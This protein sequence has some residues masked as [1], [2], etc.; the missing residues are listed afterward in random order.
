MFPVVFVYVQAPQQAS[1]P[2]KDSLC[3]QEHLAIKLFLILILILI[4]RDLP[5]L[6]WGENN[7]NAAAVFVLLTKELGNRTSN[8]KHWADKE[9]KETQG[10]RKQ[11]KTS[12]ETWNR[13]V[14]LIKPFSTLE[15][16]RNTEKPEETSAQ[17]V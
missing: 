11:R 13:R 15:T 3:V 5:Q 4:H 10:F 12:K 7:I 16:N 6:G 8:L 14:H 17:N 9:L 1:A 2:K